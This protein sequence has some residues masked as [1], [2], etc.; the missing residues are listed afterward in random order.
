MRP[1]L[2]INKP[3]AVKI[4]I[5]ATLGEMVTFLFSLVVLIFSGAPISTGQVKTSLLK[6]T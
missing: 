2:H 3:I 5:T 4:Y 1:H 6:V